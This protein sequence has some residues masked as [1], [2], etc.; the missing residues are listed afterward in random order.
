MV[1][2]E[3]EK[4]RLRDRNTFSKRIERTGLGDTS[5]EWMGVEGRKYTGQR[6]SDRQTEGELGAIVKK[7][8]RQKYIID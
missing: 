4:E 1:R 7:R 3:K 5:G 8:L 6:Q 2:D